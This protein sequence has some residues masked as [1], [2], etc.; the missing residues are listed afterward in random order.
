MGKIKIITDSNA[1]LN[2][3]EA[4]SLGVYIVPMPFI[5][6]G[7]EYFEGENITEKEFYDALRGGAD[8]KTS[9]PSRYILEEL[10]GD[11]LKDYDEVLC[12]PMSSGL[13]GFCETAKTLAENYG[14]KIHVVDNRRISLSQ[15]ESVYE[16]VAMAKLNKSGAEIKARLEERAGLSSI[17]IMVNELKYLKKG[18]R[19][20]TAAALIGSAI[21]LKPILQTRGDKFEKFAT[22]ISLGQAKKLMIDKI[23]GELDGEFREE[24]EKGNMTVSVAHTLNFDEAERFKAAIISKIPDVKFRFVDSLSLSVACHIGE[25]SLAVCISANEYLD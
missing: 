18:G 24:R 25:G 19:I 20:S 5:I 9:Q 10:F 8:V 22:A 6:D 12:I 16:A 21:R 1:G 3:G 23:A 7:E 2:R 15:K 4:E 17:Y 11:L 14:G 13:S